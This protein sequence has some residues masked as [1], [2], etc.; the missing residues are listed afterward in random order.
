M[1]RP[2]R[3]DRRRLKDGEEASN[4]PEPT[5]EAQIREQLSILSDGIAA[6]QSTDDLGSPEAN[7]AAWDDM[8]ALQAKYDRLKKKLEKNNGGKS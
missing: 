5:T 3:I 2:S 8:L 1:E 6:L 4:L 7:Q